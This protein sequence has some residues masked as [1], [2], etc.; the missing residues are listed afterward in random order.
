MGCA[1]D[2]SAISLL[3]AKMEYLIPWNRLAP[4]DAVW[5]DL[6]ETVE[7]VR[8][9]LCDLGGHGQYNAPVLLRCPDGRIAP[10]SAPMLRKLA[11]EMGAMI[12][13]R[14]LA[15]L[16]DA[17][18]PEPWSVE[19]SGPDYRGAAEAAGRRRLPVIVTEGGQSVGLLLA[20]G[21]RSIE[22]GHSP[23]AFD[24]FDEPLSRSVV[25]RTEIVAATLNTTV[26]KVALDLKAR[27]EPEKAYL[28]VEMDDGSFR[29]M[30]SR[31]LNCNVEGS[32]SDVWSRPVRHFASHLRT[33][34]ARD[35]EM[36]GRKQAQALA[37]AGSFLVLTDQG[38]PVG[39]I[40]SQV[41]RRGADL[42]GAQTY[43]MG[44]DRSYT[45]FT[46]P[47]QMLREI[48][49]EARPEKGP[50]FTNLWFTDGAGQILS[51]SSP[52]TLQKSYR[53]NV[54]IGQLR[55]ESIT[56]GE[57]PP[58]LEPAPETQE[59]TTLYVSLFGDEDDFDIPEP[60]RSLL[61]P[62]WGDSLPVAFAVT[63]KR[64]TFGPDDKVTLDVHIY[65]RC[66]LV[67]SWR[68]RA[69][70]VPVG[71]PTQS[72]SPQ[73][74]AL[75]AARTKDYMALEA[76]GPRHLSLTID[77]AP[78]GSYRFDLIVAG[79]EWADEVRLSCRIRLRREDL[80]H[81]ITKARRQLYNIAHL[82]DYRG[83][84]SG[85]PRAYQQSMAALASV[86][87]Q[88]YLKLFR[89]RE[90]DSSGAA[91]AQWIAQGN[92]KPDSKI[93]IIDQAGDFVFPW[94]LI[95][96][97]NP[98]DS[99]G[100]VP[101]GFWGIRYQIELLT[102]RLVER[103]RE[104]KPEIETEQVSIG[105]GLYDGLP[106][107]AE[108]R[109]FFERLEKVAGL[110]V[111]ADLF[112]AAPRLR[113]ALQAAD[114]HLLYFFCHGFT[115]RMAADIQIDDDLIAGFKVW[116]KS[117]PQEQQGQIQ[118]AM[119]HDDALFD[120]ADSWLQL[121]RGTAPLTMMED[122]LLAADARFGNGPLVF[123]N[124][125]ESAQVL[126]S[127]SDGF[128]PFFIDYGARGV[129]GTECPMT[130]TFANPFGLEF[131]RRFFQGQAV[132]KIL[133][134][135]RRAFL[136][137]GTDQEGRPVGNPLGLAYTLYC[138]ADVCLANRVPV[139]EAVRPDSSLR[140]E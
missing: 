129:I 137:M 140:P 18:C 68:V 105:V 5:A 35:Y 9:R 84:V 42:S 78:D 4:P 57:Q 46:I 86:G 41:V 65:Y 10:T 127:L 69:E 28:V 135:L 25:D 81:L 44:K 124:M 74:A 82:P 3:E 79:D 77:K 117:L 8:Q 76:I 33:A 95:Y 60:T 7:A 85:T 83:R 108:Q 32:G 118:D 21:H 14:R 93:Q 139:P 132:G 30:L 70:V 39:L 55:K 119:A 59:G 6:S 98:W 109:A 38:E 87:R 94:A 125:C 61:L 89:P 107:A 22:V 90:R 23:Q 114:Q 80:T 27:R 138:D 66:N 2:F 34:E 16:M 17:L 26:A 133:L 71:Q 37:D 64:R 47:E 106:G 96:D 43:E 115:E 136:N 128:I 13:K 88:L 130:S 75:L 29:V 110:Q 36:V 51:K 31:D 54:N 121:T 58:I 12:L 48:A 52:L 97:R 102:E 45:L 113:Q 116:Y 91:V 67:Q 50:R 92:L 72:A 120:V 104:I 40:L 101:E 131:F 24:L 73:E 122:T 56:R 19:S 20:P 112:N 111:K 15:D 1:W 126:P 100:V 99:K 49:P 63:P 11:Q 134:D 53:L 62:P 123:L 103:Y